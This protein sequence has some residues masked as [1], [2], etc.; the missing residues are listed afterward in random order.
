MEGINIRLGDGWMGFLS[1]WAM[2]GWDFYPVGRWM[3]GIFIRLGDGWMGSSSNPISI[4]INPDP[5]V[6]GLDFNNATDG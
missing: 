2:D 5:S 3:D 1:G 6:V 4:R